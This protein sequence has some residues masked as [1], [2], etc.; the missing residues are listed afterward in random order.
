MKLDKKIIITIVV[1]VLIVCG[2]IVFAVLRNNTGS[3]E[4][5]LTAKLEEGQRYMKDNDYD[6]AVETYKDALDIDDT[7]VYA[8]VRLSEAYEGLNKTDDAVTALE[9]AVRAIESHYNDSKEV[10]DNSEVAYKKLADYYTKNEQKDKAVKLLSRAVEIVQ[11]E[12]LK[13]LYNALGD[14]GTDPVVEKDGYVQLGSYPTTEIKGNNLTDAITKANYNEAGYTQAGDVIYKRITAKDTYLPAAFGGAEYR[15][16][17]CEPINW[18][19]LKDDGKQKVLITENVVDCYP[20]NLDYENVAWDTSDI[21]V[22]LNST[23]LSNAFSEEEQKTI[24]T[25]KLTAPL[26]TLYGIGCGE[27]TED[28]VYLLNCEEIAYTDYGYEKEPG[29]E[30]KARVGIPTD[31]ADTRGTFSA[32]SQKGCA[33]WLRSMGYAQDSACVVYDNGIVNLSGLM[34]ITTTCGVR[35]VI[36]ISDI[37]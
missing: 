7:S 25:T 22:W 37:K 10:L 14:P 9:D 17:K 6:S 19:I 11:S 1:I 24:L 36:V 34:S 28:K 3:T 27:E 2:G 16:F 20:F 8:Y 5:K 4:H 26:N 13:T 29:D 18:K 32:T 21:R 33:W 12:D 35:P 15:Y 30:D 23:F 31:Y